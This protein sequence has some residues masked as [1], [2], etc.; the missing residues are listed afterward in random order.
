MAVGGAAWLAAL[1]PQN[2]A[3][4]EQVWR[5]VGGGLIGLLV[6]VACIFLINLV[7]APY[8]QRNEAR[9]LAVD[10]RRSLRSQ[11]NELVRLKDTP[12]DIP[13]IMQAL[14][15]RYGD[16]ESLRI[17]NEAIQELQLLGQIHHVK[18]GKINGWL[19]LKRQSASFAISSSDQL[20]IGIN[21]DPGVNVAAT[22]QRIP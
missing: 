16:A 9:E 15:L 6:A 13:E 14:G 21:G 17:V 11:L 5:A 10:W 20:G 8:K 4:S 18:R 7:L 1:A 19:P 22:N 12:I 2:A 3:V